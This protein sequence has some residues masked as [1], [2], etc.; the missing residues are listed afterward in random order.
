MN[1]TELS[2]KCP[3]I[4]VVKKGECIEK[5][6]WG[7]TCFISIHGIV[8]ETVNTQWIRRTTEAS[9]YLQKDCIQLVIGNGDTSIDRQIEEGLTRMWVGEKARLDLT[10]SPGELKYVLRSS[11]NDDLLELSIELTLEKIDSCEPLWRWNKDKLIGSAIVSKLRGNE[12][13]SAKRYVDAFF[14]YSIA[15]KYLTMVDPLSTDNDDAKI[16]LAAIRNNIAFVQHL[17]KNFEEVIFISSLVVDDYRDNIKARLRRAAAYI[18]LQDYER[19]AKDLEVV[20][21][22]EKNNR[23][24]LRLAKDLSKRQKEF[25]LTMA[26]KM[27]KLFS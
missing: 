24:A 6:I 20:F 7:S 5:P 12:L 22:V 9:E 23:D 2:R 27:K 13:F 11:K 3:N 26:D 8:S 18:E 1:K 25:D 14:R 16:Q 4:T 15:A 21:K 19:A 17:Y 10:L